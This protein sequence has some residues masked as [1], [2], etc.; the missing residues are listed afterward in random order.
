MSNIMERALDKIEGNQVEV[1][2]V[3]GICGKGKSS[4]AIQHI[5]ANPKDKYIYI[6]PYLDEITRVLVTCGRGGVVLS[7]PQV[8]KG[9][10][11]KINHFKNMLLKGDNIVCT[12]ALIDS[13]DSECDDIIDKYGYTL[14]MDEVHN[15]IN[16]YTFDED[17]INLL[18]NSKFF[19]VGERGRLTWTGSYKG[20]MFNEF[21]NLCEQGALYYYG[22]KLYIWAFPVGLFKS[23]KKVYVL[24]WFF[25]AQLQAY[26]YKFNG[27]KYD[28]KTVELVEGKYTLKNY[29]VIEAMSD[30]N[31]LLGLINI[32]EGNMNYTIHDKTQLTSS[33][34]NR[35][36]DVSLKEINLNL[37]NYFRN[38]TKGGSNVNM[39]TCKKEKQQVLKGKG[40]SNGFIPINARATNAYRHKEN[41]AYI[42][43]IFMN[44]IEK[45]FFTSQGIHVNEELYALTELLQWVFRSRVRDGKPINLY[46]PA[47]RMREQIYKVYL[48]Y[49]S[50][51]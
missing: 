9:R 17:D 40:Y 50:K 8:H 38:V 14:I 27:I 47:Y 33:W 46:L 7:Q 15:V 21:R 44:P 28:M 18:Y 36:S 39:W 45:R 25:E 6:T 31:R 32:Y 10:G 34:Y 19:T 13:W 37:Y 42:Y 35:C 23:M 11:K 43:N 41:C 26:Y 16:P 49:S 1:T 20:K 48:Q 5:I 3:D 51:F 2:V 24:T 30:S 22:G 4:W 12:H 29:D